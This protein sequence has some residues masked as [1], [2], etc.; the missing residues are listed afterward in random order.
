MLAAVA[1]AAAAAS[2][3]SAC[4]FTMQDNAPI[5]REGITMNLSPTVLLFSV[6]CLLPEAGAAPL[7]IVPAKPGGGM[8]L[9]CK[10]VQQGLAGSM[11]RKEPIRISYMPGGIGAV[12]W[13]AIASQRRAEP[14]TLVG[15]SGGSLL[16]LAQGKYGKAAPADV[17][18]VAAF[19]ADYGMVAVRSDS[20]Y[21]N[22]RDLVEAWKRDAAKVAVGAGGT[23]GSQDWLKV[24]MLA[25]QGGVDPRRLRIVAFEGGG[26]SFTA[27]LAGHVQAVSGDVSELSHYA[28]AGNAG[29]KIRVLAVLADKRLDGAL[30]GVPTAREQG[31][32]VA[33][34]IIRGVYMGPQVSEADYRKWVHRF[35]QAL[36]APGFEELRAAHGLYPFALT[37][38]AL[39]DYVNKTVANYGK[40]AK[41]LGLVR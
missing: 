31:F 29:D 13:S 40:Q 9:T 5:R 35:D 24:A 8:D 32:D 18:W 22:L 1:E 33:W 34:P 14:D 16:N 25:K 6:C 30:A 10:L 12:A 38:A 7:C 41:E 20:P 11:A 4:R 27:L 3:K 2:V 36:A 37:G 39:A 26:E 28:A 23:I 15:F 19:G 17:R 21:R